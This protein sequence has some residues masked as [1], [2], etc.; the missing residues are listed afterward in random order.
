MRRVLIANR[1]EIACRIIRSCR[2]LGL[3]TIAV[4]SEAD[5]NALH[6][7]LAGGAEPIGP[8]PARQSCLDIDAVVAAA[9]AA[10]VDA[11]NRAM[12]PRRDPMLRRTWSGSRGSPGSAGDE[13]PSYTP[14]T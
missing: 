6:V 1:G 10:E 8:A 5:A 13:K 3:E 9:R 2:G 12:A 4:Y 14:K 7:E 11:V